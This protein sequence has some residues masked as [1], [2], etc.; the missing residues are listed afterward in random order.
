[1]NPSSSALLTDLYEL[2]MA[3]G[4]WKRGV[5]SQRVVFDYFYRRQPFSGGY[6]VFAGLGTLLDALAGFRFSSKDIQFLHT[7]GIFD[8]AFLEY[9]S[10]FSFKGTIHS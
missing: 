10:G 6:S 7:L 8:K 9:L 2:T 4:Y 1:M 5:S 3:Q